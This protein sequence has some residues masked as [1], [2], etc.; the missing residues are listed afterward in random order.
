ML[1]E[2]LQ[3]P[4][5]LAL[6]EISLAEDLSPV[7]I[8][9]T[10]IDP[11]HNDVTSAATLA[12]E[13]QL[14]GKIHTKK[15]GIV[16]GLPVAEAVFK[17][18]DPKVKFKCD[19]VDGDRLDEGQILAKVNGPGPVLL[20]AERTAL[21]FLGRMSGIATLTRK[22]VDAVAHTNAI[23]LDTRKTAPGHRLLDKY[24]VRQGGGE[25]HRMGLYDMVLIKNNHIDSAG[26]IE[27]AVE[28]VRLEYGHE[29]AIEVEVRTLNELEIA[30]SLH[31]TR[32]MLD[33][34][35]LETMR[36]AVDHTQ[37]R[38]PLEASGNVNLETVASIAE[39]GVDY[40]SVGSLTHS[41]PVLDISMHV[42]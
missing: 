28:K 27:A 29:Y 39:T 9:K 1:P 36:R 38:A 30:L 4:T 11:Y 22:F 32:I 41:A 17:F 6:L 34:M 20:A 15:S 8:S 35:D 40:I 33:N 13:V 23:I 18:I 24:A 42:D 10:T 14:R 19:V 12:Q 26:G 7:G 3:H 37:G 5:V 21:N 31:P 2:S 25:N 16:A